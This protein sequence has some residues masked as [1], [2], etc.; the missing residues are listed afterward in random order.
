MAME[1]P[2]GEKISIGDL[3]DH[4]LIGEGAC[5]AV[6]RV[7]GPEGRAM[8]LKTFDDAAVNRGLIEKTTLRLQAGGWPEGVM[9]VIASDFRGESAFVLTPLMADETGDEALT[10]WSLQ[11]RLD[12]YPGLDSWKV[13]RSI[14]RALAAMHARH[15]PHGNLKPGNVFFD[16]NG[17]VRLRDWALGQMPGVDLAEFTDALL[18][19]PP[20]QLRDAAC[21]PADGYRCDVFAFGVLAFRVL[22]GRFPRC[23]ATFSQVAPPPGKAAPSGIRA[24]LHKIASNLEAQRDCNWPD[25]AKTSLEQ[26]LREWIDK[27]LRLDPAERPRDMC[28]VAQ[29]LAAYDNE[30]RSEDRP[31]KLLDE[32]RHAGFRSRRLLFALSAA[33]ALAMVFAALWQIRGNQIAADQERHRGEIADLKTSLKSE[34]AARDAAEAEAHE[35]GRALVDEREIW[36]TRFK[37]SQLAADRLFTWAL[38]QDHRRLPPLDGR[39]LR[40]RHLEQQFEDFLEHSLEIPDL[41]D[42]RAMAKLRLCEI[43]LALGDSA[44]AARRHEEASRMWESL[45]MGSALRLRMAT[46]QLLLALLMQSTSDPGAA[47]AFNDAREAL[48]AVPRGDVDTDRLDHLLAVLDLHESK[49]HAARGDDTRALEQLMRASQTLIRIAGQRPDAAVLR[50]ELAASHHSTATILEGIGNP[51]DAAEV[52]ALAIAELGKL[53]E[54]NPGDPALRLQMAGCYAAMAEA[55]VF[56]GDL[57]KADSLSSEA[58]KLLTALLSVQKPAAAGTVTLK[59]SQLGLRAGILRDRGRPDDA[60]KLYDEGI[61]MLEGIRASAP[62]DA[63]PAYRLALLWWQKARLLGDTGSRDEEIALLGR[64]R[65]LLASLDNPDAVSGPLPEQVR[66]AA[67]Y[68]AGDLG[69][70]LQIANRKGDAARV[71]ESA[72]SIWQGLAETRPESGEYQEGLVWSQ[73]RLADLK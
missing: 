23:H 69:H 65:D 20:E 56:S 51:G 52:R 17:S 30:A 15:A 57:N 2:Q 14:A 22:T 34:K 24:D 45:P 26:G 46:N 12:D 28:E 9:P 70:A 41:V 64:A 39:E 71:F 29:G 55:A 40:L 16:E 58:G 38:E 63:M 4:E 73:Q 42:E 3:S 47:T 21:Y 37:A 53:R 67:A 8:A 31:E 11:H 13:V 5:G 72:V 68:L 18:Y 27:C 10:P 60:M 35:I 50:S 59:A 36:I 32:R 49:L 61:S 33:A 7:T 25:A 43:S 6:F 48:A 1:T 54:K 66:R 44:A 19:Q 62:A